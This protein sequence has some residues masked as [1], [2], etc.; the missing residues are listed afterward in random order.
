[1]SNEYIKLTPYSIMNVKLAPHVLSFPVSKT[2]TSYGT[3]EA[4]FCSLMDIFFD[5]TNKC[6]IQSHEFA[7]KLFI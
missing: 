4:L 5:I 6:N 1:M 3:P 7:R 2:L